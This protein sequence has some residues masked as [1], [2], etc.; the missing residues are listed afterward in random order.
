MSSGFH[1]FLGSILLFV[2]VLLPIQSYQDA[3]RSE[4]Q[5]ARGQ[6]NTMGEGKLYSSIHS[7]CVKSCLCAWQLAVL[8]EWVYYVDQ[9]LERG[10]QYSSQVQRGSLGFRKF[11]DQ[12]HS[13]PLKSWCFCH[14]SSC[15]V[16]WT[17]GWLCEVLCSF[18]LMQTLSL[19]S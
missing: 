17:K 7:N 12:T 14:V 16:L 2:K 15:Y 10:L 5:L 3:W 6:I 19:L 1:E 8:E 18:F 4:S 11:Y 13:K 9:S